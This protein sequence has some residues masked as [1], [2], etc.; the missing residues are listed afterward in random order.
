M[1]ACRRLWSS[2]PQPP[3]PST[4]SCPVRS[5]RTKWSTRQIASITV[6][7]DMTICGIQSGVASSPWLMSFHLA[8]PI[9][10]WIA[11]RAKKTAVTA[12]TP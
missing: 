10:V 11:L 9:F 1:R 5:S 7:T 4:P 2:S 12:A 8:E 3:S 6:P